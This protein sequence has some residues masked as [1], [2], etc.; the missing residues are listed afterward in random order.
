ML[1]TFGTIEASW[2]KQTAYR[3]VEEEGN[4][5][6]GSTVKSYKVLDRNNLGDSEDAIRRCGLLQNRVEKMIEGL[7]R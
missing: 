1:G 7:R 2:D 4:L 5:A 3:G 6:L